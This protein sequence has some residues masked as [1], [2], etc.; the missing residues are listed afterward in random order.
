MLDRYAVA[1]APKASIIARRALSGETGFQIDWSDPKNSLY[2]R[3][4]NQLPP[5]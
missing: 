1:A 2:F 4:V 3:Q 5:H